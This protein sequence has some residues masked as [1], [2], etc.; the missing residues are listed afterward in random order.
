MN[1]N[2]FWGTLAAVL[3]VV[4]AGLVYQEEASSIASLEDMFSSSRLISQKTE[5]NI[6][7]LV[8]ANNRFGFDLFTQLQ[9]ES[10]AQNIF[11]SPQSVAI[12]LAMLRNGTSGETLQEITSTLKLEQLAS[13]GI[14]SSYSKLIETL[15][16]ADSNLELAIANS[17]WINQDVRLAD[18]FVKTTLDFYQGRV[19]NLDFADPAAKNTI[20]QWVASNTAH[21]ITQIVDTTSPEDALYLINA[22]YFKGSWT[23]KF[24]PQATVE[25]PF[26]LQSDTSKSVSMMSQTGDYRYYENEQFQAIRLPYGETAEMG[27]YIFLPQPD[28]TLE[29]FNQE[30][31]LD[32]WQEWLTQM[33]SQSGNISLPKFKLE[34]DTELQNALSTLGMSQA[35]NPTQADFS[36]MTD[37]A[38]AIDTIKHKAIIEVNEEG[39]EAAGVTSIGVRI[40][41]AMPQDQPFNMNIDR[42]FFFAIR[43]DITET[44]LFM[45]N[46]VEP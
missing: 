32:N 30:L 37:S 4:L 45:G 46:V 36:A 34:Y 29:Q 11:I 15:T 43:D 39:T 28:T 13:G 16:T 26:Y 2:T 5:A 31:S 18:Q 20:N 10:P 3:L 7:Q 38:V 9:Q 25:Q 42:P 19:T 27:M 22:I 40:T 8:D 14:D 1:R 21:K 23:N 44:M 35:F 6:S 17:L 12:A 24:D 33:R 41:S